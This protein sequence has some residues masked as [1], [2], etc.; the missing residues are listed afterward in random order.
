MSRKRFALSS[1]PALLIGAA[2]STPAHAD[3]WN[4]VAQDSEGAQGWSEN[5]NSQAGAEARALRECNN[6]SN[7]GDCEIAQCIPNNGKS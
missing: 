5:Y 2:L 3:K 4:C 7:T 6:V 1:L